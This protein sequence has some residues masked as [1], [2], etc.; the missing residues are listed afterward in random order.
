M[1]LTYLVLILL[2]LQYTTSV[3][4]SNWQILRNS[5]IQL[6]N[7]SKNEQIKVA[8]KLPSIIRPTLLFIGDSIMLS[9][10]S[11]SNWCSNS[12][13]LQ[14]YDTIYI[15]DWMHLDHMIKNVIPDVDSMKGLLDVV[16]LNFAVLHNLQKSM[17]HSGYSTE[18]RVM[19][20]HFEAMMQKEI[21]AYIN[22]GATAIITTPPKICDEKFYGD[23]KHFIEHEDEYLME[24]AMRIKKLEESKPIFLE[25]TKFY[26]DKV[27]QPHFYFRNLTNITNAYNFCTYS[28]MD[29]HGSELYAERMRNFVKYFYLTFPALKDKLY[30]FDYYNITKLASCAYVPDGRHYNRTFQ[31]EY[32]QT[33]FCHLLEN[34]THS[35]IMY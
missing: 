31:I 12:T 16:V 27:A 2:L 26:D 24:C 15:S 11:L 7:L 33:P 29:M 14:L 32:A 23:Y 17:N 13:D 9:H 22:I 1:E 3:S 34:I 18:F 4:K 28:T 21:L 5:S 20:A 35:N 30:L 25:H 10:Y 19:T 6:V 8:K